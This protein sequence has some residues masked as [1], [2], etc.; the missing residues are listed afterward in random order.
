M[1]HPA[2]SWPTQRC[3]THRCPLGTAT[4]GW[5]LKM[6]PQSRLPAWCLLVGLGLLLARHLTAGQ[7]LSSWPQALGHPLVTSSAS[8]DALGVPT[9]VVD[10][11]TANIVS[12]NQCAQRTLGT[13]HS[14]VGQALTAYFPST[15]LEQLCLYP[16]Y[17][18]TCKTTKGSC[19][20]M[21][22]HATRVAH[23]VTVVCQEVATTISLDLE[24]QI[25]RKVV[26]Q[27]ANEVRNKT[28]AAS[29]MLERIQGVT[30]DNS[31]DVRRE[32]TAIDVDITRCIAQLAE[33]DQLIET[34]LTFHKI[35]TGTYK[36]TVETIDLAATMHTL[37][38]T[39]AALAP[40][41]VR[42]RV[43][44]PPDMSASFDVYV[45]KH[46]A[47]N[48]LNNARAAIE[49][50][51]IVFALLTYDDATL[52]FGIHDEGRGVPATI[53]D[54]LF[55]EDAVN[56]NSIGIGLGLLS[57]AKFAEAIGGKCWLE[58]TRCRNHEANQTGFSDFRFRLPGQLF[59]RQCSQPDDLL[60]LLP[61]QLSVFIVDDSGLIRRSIRH[62]I[63]KIMTRLNAH[64]HFF[65]FATCEAV[66]IDQLILAGS[67]SLITIDQNLDG[68]G[69][70]LKGAD[71]IRTLVRRH[72]EGVI[73]SASGDPDFAHIHRL[74]GAHCVFGKPLPNN[75]SLLQM[76][77]ATYRDRQRYHD[78]KPVPPVVAV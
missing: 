17:Y 34:R 16:S 63:G 23:I 12:A 2:H 47:T 69:G 51:E 13:N 20:D 38:R 15:S 78:I 44:C 19:V 43:D 58:A 66:P 14:V 57:C 31:L 6:T 40:K 68:A 26:A 4:S 67:N 61:P 73:V 29:S 37:C 10:A 56:G 39:A 52:T 27:L 74:L 9:L 76:L 1:L 3:A 11:T 64:V 28:T 35:Y 53:A 70:K 48:Y 71:L 36:T 30:A 55:Q 41:S 60:T 45:F 22:L 59:C 18:A 50:G 8:L 62:K 33:A 46:V 72:F 65:E 25:Q 77:A 54:G 21:V 32:L 49:H 24:L 42:F 7:P 75:D 5:R